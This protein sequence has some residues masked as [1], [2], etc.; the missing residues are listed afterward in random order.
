MLKNPNVPSDPLCEWLT[1]ANWVM[2]PLNTSVCC[3]IGPCQFTNASQLASTQ[4]LKVPILL[5]S[6]STL[7]AKIIVAARMPFPET[8]VQKKLRLEKTKLRDEAPPL[9]PPR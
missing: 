9:E 3:L 1:G 4:P 7:P 2:Q 5:H 6:H 8:G